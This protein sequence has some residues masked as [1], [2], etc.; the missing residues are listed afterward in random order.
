VI[1]RADFQPARS[2]RE[3]L[4]AT[5]PKYA[6]SEGATITILDPVALAKFNDDREYLTTPDNIKDDFFAIDAWDANGEELHL[7]SS[8]DSRFDAD[9]GELVLP[10]SY[11]DSIADVRCMREDDPAWHLPAES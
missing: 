4:I 3:L 2:A 5:S 7:A 11:V 9:R 10:D 1:L 6:A 8:L